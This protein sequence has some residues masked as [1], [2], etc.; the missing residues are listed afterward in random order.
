MYWEDGRDGVAQGTLQS[1]RETTTNTYEGHVF[2]FTQA[3]NKSNEIARVLIS[4][5]Q[6]SCHISLSL[7][8]SYPLVNLVIYPH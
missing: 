1:G 2:Y 4:K 5:N 8:L 6:V 3:S 7:L